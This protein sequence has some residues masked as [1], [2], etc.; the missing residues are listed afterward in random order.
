MAQARAAVAVRDRD[1]VLAEAAKARAEA[2]RIAGRPFV[3]SVMRG[4]LWGQVAAL[5]AR[6]KNQSLWVRARKAVLLAAAMV[7][8]RV[9]GG[10]FWVSHY[11]T[12][13]C[14]AYSVTAGRLSRTS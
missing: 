3:A 2:R 9:R 4:S 13:L 5:C 14:A 7:K 8:L 1:A 12:V 6:S 10:F 11:D